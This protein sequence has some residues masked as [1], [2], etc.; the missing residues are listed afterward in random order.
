MSS[1]TFDVM[2][3]SIVLSVISVILVVIFFLVIRETLPKEREDA[4]ELDAFALVREFR[5]RNQ[6]LE[7]KLVDLKVKMEILSLRVGKM[8]GKDGQKDVS[9]QVLAT[10]SPKESARSAP[11]SF[12]YEKPRVGVDPIHQ[13]ILAAVREAAGAAT[14]R[15]IQLKVGRSREHVARTL[16]VLQKQGLLYRNQNSRPFSYSIT[17]EGE[18]ELNVV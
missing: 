4:N 3:I 6:A 8:S 7:E 5:N 2:L 15:E 17:Q 10:I 9:P 13:E 1:L 14:S 12:S 11:A 16:N 18:R